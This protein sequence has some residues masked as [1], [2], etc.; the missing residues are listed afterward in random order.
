VDLHQPGLP[1]QLGNGAH[2]EQAPLD[3]RHPGA[4]ALHLGHVVRAEHDGAPLR[5]QLTDRLA[6]G[7]GRFRIQPAG[8]LV[9]EQRLGVVQQRPDE[10]QLLPHPLAEVAALVVLTPP[11]TEALHPPPSGLP[12][13]GRVAVVELEEERRFSRAVRRS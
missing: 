5:G 13:I 12:R 4:E 11:E 3:H 9:E 7:P 1:A 8:G 10:R 2:R 6:H